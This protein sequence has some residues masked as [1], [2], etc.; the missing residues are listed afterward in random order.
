MSISLID[1][2]DIITRSNN[3]KDYVLIVVADEPWDNSNEL[4]YNLQEKFNNYAAY[5]LDGQM[6]QDYPD[7]NQ[8]T[9]TIRVSSTTP[10]PDHILEFIF[11]ISKVLEPD[12]VMI[13]TEIL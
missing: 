7:C 3:G 11:E 6:L 13:E 12:G 8:N 1:K 10:I 4:K 9:I 2:I 5:F